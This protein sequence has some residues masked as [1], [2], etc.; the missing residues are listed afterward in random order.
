MRF[1]LEPGD[2]VAARPCGR[3]EL[4]PGDL[5]LLVKWTAGLPSGY[6]IH[7]VL[8][9]LSLNKKTFLLTKGD[10]NFLPDWPPEAFLAAGKVL[11]F[12]RNGLRFDLPSGRAGKFLLPVYSL[13]A[14]KLLYLAGFLAAVLFS[15]ACRLLPAPLAEPLSLLYLAWES[16]LYPALLRLAS[17]PAR[18][19]GGRPAEAGPAVKCGRVLANETWSG[20]VKVADYLIVERGARITVLPGT[21]IKFSRREPWFFPVLRAGQD[22]SLRELDSGLAKILVY[23]EFSAQGSKE[24]PVRLGGDSFGGIHA[25]GSGKVSLKDCAAAEAGSW[26]LSA[27][28]SGFL[29]L[30]NVS[31]SSC[32]R[33]AE[34]SGQG[35]ASLKNCVF[36]ATGGPAARVL[37]EG[38][39][40]FSGGSVN[41]ADGPAFEVSGRARAAFYG[42]AVTDAGCGISASGKAGVL[43]GDCAV[44]GSRRG[45]VILEGASSFEAAR[46][47]FKN[48]AFGL[49]A[50][51]RHEI[52]L[53]DCLFS[54]NTGQAV[55][56]QGTSSLTGAAW[57]FDRNGAGVS[58]AGQAG[59]LFRECSFTG[60]KGP[61]VC[62]GGAGQLL[63]QRSSFT[64]NGS[65]LASA[66]NVTCIAADCVFERQ[67]GTDASFSDR[68][69][70]RFYGCVFRAGGSALELSGAASVYG[71]KCVFEDNG[72][73]AAET[74]GRGKLFLE[75]CSSSG[76]NSSFVLAGTSCARLT[77]VLAGSG[78]SPCVSLD[79]SA[80]LCAAAS[81]FS[82]GTDAVYCSASGRAEFS[83]CSLSSASGAALNLRG[84]G[85]SLYGC[86]LR[87]R[88][89]ILSGFPGSVDINDCEINAGAYGID[90]GSSSFSAAGL[91]IKGGEM[92]GIVLSAGRNRLDDVRVEGAPYP[93]ISLSKGA[94]LR[95]SEV[96]SDGLAWLPPAVPAPG[97]SFKR[98]LFR[99]AAYTRAWPVFSSVYRLIYLSAPSAARVL[100]RG[101]FMRALYL[102]RGM[103]DKRWVPALSDMD[104]ACVLKDAAPAGDFTAYSS[105]RRRF[106]V[107]K[108]IFPF[109][110]ELMM[111]TEADFSAFMNC[112]GVKGAE[113]PG[114]SRLLSGRPVRIAPEAAGAGL[115]DATEA[116]YAYTLLL[117]HFFT[118]NLPEPFLRRNCLKNLVDVRRYLDGSSSCRLSRAAY[119]AEQG[120]PLEGYMSLEKGEA[121]Y[122]AFRA[123]HA[124]SPAKEGA[125]GTGPPS[126]APHRTGWFNRAA[127]ERSCAAMSE[128]AGME[129]GVA[130][131]SLYRVYLVLSDEAAGDKAAFLR[132]CG[133]LAEERAVSRLLSASPLVLTE[134]SFAALSRLPYL[135]N[136]VLW[137]DLAAASAG[138]SGP[139]DGGLY[140][141]NLGPVLS[142][143][144]PAAVR[145][146]AR[147]AAR[148]FCASWRSLW[149]E[150]P[151]HYFYTRTAGLRLL[152][153][154]G[155]S[156]G[157]SCPGPLCEEL[158]KKTGAA[159]PEWKE[160]LACGRGRN[161]YEYVSAQ[162]AI[163]GRL[164][165]EG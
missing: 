132:A 97:L 7:R 64:G 160:F 72:G 156:R 13:A 53:S 161:N 119:A 23:G 6:V 37:D 15:L 125:S 130:L 103:A 54:G 123:L 9:N 144:G 62:A 89:G 83:D 75:D 154:T 148:H 19:L 74:S 29:E 115:A 8:L 145:A 111:A 163:L 92:G 49:S 91:R 155:E 139:D 30:E 158:F 31:F 127:F 34:V 28:D 107:L 151:P 47:S 142:R 86:S 95:F 39:V 133:A 87:G 101:G 162:A 77:K 120:L 33:G 41:G 4:R 50:S 2:A 3:E 122:Q 10:A 16:R 149:E 90:S 52:I 36:S 85:A 99:F 43:A 140:F 165:D 45:A 137:A 164:A 70:G 112:W 24:A 38:R 57:V 131:D 21:E 136:P 60:I 61:A 126:P 56:L 124:A 46:C 143:P 14:N 93:G 134:S 27:R 128:K 147:L 40:I 94:R 20:T 82:S 59:L 106:G 98:L 150:M 146:A 12:E 48:G 109:T 81:S 78:G 138:G 129:M 22:G 84:G 67:S 32:R 73:P 113:F 25:L 5:A 88:G 110:G 65:G 157:F 104:L 116:F 135:N 68:S 79:G 17:A 80:R 153:E 1:L 69:G 141:F 121:A 117:R 63:L 96:Y 11:A 108:N 76:K 159:V 118:E 42:A 105:L 114:A 35:A 55:S 58:S 51:G 100:L 102:Y 44:E 18:P 152:L 71:E 66:G 26:A